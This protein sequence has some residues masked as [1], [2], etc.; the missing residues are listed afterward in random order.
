MLSLPNKKI[1]FI[2]IGGSG[3]SGIAEIFHNL[4]FCVSGSDTHKGPYIARLQEI[5]I[6]ISF[7]HAKQNICAKDV[8][9]VSSAIKPSNPELKEAIKQNIP[10]F[11]RADMLIELMRLKTS[12]LVAGTHG[13]TTTSSILSHVFE[14]IGLDPTAVIGGKVQ[15]FGS[16]AK[17]GKGKY[18]IAEADESDGSFL[19]FHPQ[20]AVVTNIDKDHLE[21]YGNLEE[22]LSAFQKF[23]SHVISDGTVCLCLDNAHTS[24]LLP[25]IK[26]NVLTYGLHPSA[27]ITAVD[28]ETSGLQ[29]TFMPVIFHKKYPKVSLKLPGK[30]NISNALASFAVAYALGLDIKKVG[31]SLQYFSGTL[32]RYTL[33]AQINEHLIIDDYAHNPTKIQTVLMGTK[34]SF[35]K[36]KI[37]AVFQPHKYSRLQQQGL[38]FAQSFYDAD[39]VILTPVYSAGEEPIEGINSTALA[40]EIQKQHPL[41]LETQVKTSENFEEAVESCLEY[42]QSEPSPSGVV[43]LM[44]GAGNLAS[45][46]HILKE[47]LRSET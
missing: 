27:D 45:A 22:I 10:I 34:E 7:L 1:H 42:L 6:P 15:N 29:T 43:F 30:Y 31:K 4:G 36:K 26:A 35:P 20:I 28:I 16:N 38:E 32:H 19:R 46:G 12:I 33:L 5:G 9:V 39:H 13:K 21:Y 18:F 25:Y 14:M 41:G 23:V 3:M 2:G 8:I 17:C 40:N 11:H 44:L 24:K 47:R 37:V